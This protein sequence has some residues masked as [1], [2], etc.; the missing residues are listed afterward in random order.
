MEESF[1][2]YKRLE[3]VYNR[4]ESIT[5]SGDESSD[6]LLESIDLCY[7]DFSKA[8]NDDFNSR[9]ALAVLFQFSRQVNGYELESL[10]VE[11][12]ENL[13]DIFAKLGG[14]VLGLFHKDEIDS[15]FKAQIEE[16]INQ[17]NIARVA[18]DWELSDSIRDKLKPHGV[19]IQDTSDGTNWKLI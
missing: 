19:E 4:L 3:G 16:L 5:T 12:Q 7:L 8:M 6:E 17:R 11:L 14:E 9:E 18:K 1:S 2:A 13:L 15:E 10:T